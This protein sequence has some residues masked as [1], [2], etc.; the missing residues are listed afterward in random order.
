VKKTADTISG[1]L[2]FVAFLPYIW[3]IINNPAAGPS[4]I[5]WLIW[6][7]VD[8]LAL[9]AMKKRKAFCGQL[10]GAVAG[11]WIIAV[12]AIISGKPTTMGVIEWICIVGAT[13]GIVLWQ[14]TDNADTAIIC[15]QLTVFIGA[16]PT[17]VSSYTNPSKEDPIAWS[18]WFVSCICALFAIKKWNLAEAL[19]PLTFTAIETTM[20]VL[21]VIRPHWL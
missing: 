8:T 16:F 3:A 13:L 11:A 10:I 17:F 12:L 9:L 14:K 15:S 1:I 21:V 6:A 2:F 5:S 4:P 18:V 20:V 7:S 19:Q